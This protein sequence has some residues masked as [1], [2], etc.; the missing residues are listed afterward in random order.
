MLPNVAASVLAESA[1]PNDAMVNDQHNNSP[2]DRD[3]H[4][5]DVESS[6]GCG[7]YDREQKPTDYR[8]NNAECDVHDDTLTAFVDDLTSDESC[9]K[10]EDE[11]TN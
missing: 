5:V 7:A 11:P 2:D 1:T 8:S 9:D 4:A 3:D 6:D 10:T